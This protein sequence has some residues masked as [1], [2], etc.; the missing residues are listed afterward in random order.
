MAYRSSSVNTGNSTTPSVAVPASVDIGDIVLIAVTADNVLIDFTGKFPAG[1]T[2]LDQVG[3][4]LDGEKAAIGWKRL[5]AVDSG[6]Y[7]FTSMGVAATDWVCEAIA[8]SGRDTINPPVQN[9]VAV[10]NTGNASPIAPTASTLTAVAGDDLLWVGGLDVTNNTF[11]VGYTAPSGYTLRQGSK[12]GWSTIGI[13]SKDNVSAG[14]TGSVA[15]SVTISS[16]TSGW[17]AWLVRIPT[18]IFRRPVG[19]NVQQV[20]VQ[21][22]ASW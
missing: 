21:R 8:F 2:L 9:T 19:N 3:P 4:T 15:G 11:T 1:F 16:G 22:A 12:Q 20:A 17:D 6:T 7:T 10:N 13:A 18:A 14:A 5:S